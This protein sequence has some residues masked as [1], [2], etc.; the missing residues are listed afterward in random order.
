[1]KKIIL[2]SNIIGV[3]VV[4][5]I[6]AII[7]VK[8]GKNTGENKVNDNHKETTSEAEL[9]KEWYDVYKTFLENNSFDEL[10]NLPVVQSTGTS[11]GGE[12]KGFFLYDMD[13]DSVPELLIQKIYGNFTGTLV[14]KYDKKTESVE[15]SDIY[16]ENQSEGML[17]IEFVSNYK[18]NGGNGLLVYNHYPALGYRKDNGNLISF[19]WNGGDNEYGVLIK[20]YDKDINVVTT[21]SEK[22]VASE[23]DK[24]CLEQGDK[25]IYKGI[26]DNYIPIKFI[27][28][29]KENIDKFVVNEYKSVGMY[30]YEIEACDLSYSFESNKE[31]EEILARKDIMKEEYK[32][33]EESI[34][35]I[36]F[37]KLSK[38]EFKSEM[39]KYEK[40]LSKDLMDSE[41]SGRGKKKFTSLKIFPIFKKSKT[42]YYV[43]T[44]Q[45]RNIV[46]GT[47]DKMIKSMSDKKKQK[48]TISHLNVLTKKQ[49]IQYVKESQ[50]YA[51]I[52]IL[53]IDND[54][55][56]MKV[57]DS[58]N[59]CYYICKF[60]ID[61]KIVDI[62]VDEAYKEQ[63]KVV[64]KFLLNA[65]EEYKDYKY[66]IRDIDNDGRLEVVFAKTIEEL[67]LY[68]YDKEM[69]LL[70]KEELTY[71]EDVVGMTVEGV[72]IDATH[73]V[74]GYHSY[75]IKNDKFVYEDD[76]YTAIDDTFYG[77]EF[78][79]L[80]SNTAEYFAQT[81]AIKEELEK[82]RLEKNKN[83]VSAYKNFLL[84][85]DYDEIINQVVN[86][87]MAV[88]MSGGTV[89]GFFLYDINSD[90]QPELMV[91]K[92]ADQFFT[93]TLVYTYNKS[94]KCVER[95]G[96]SL[97]LEN[98]KGDVLISKSDIR[99]YKKRKGNGLLIY[100]GVE[101]LGYRKDNGW[102]V[103]FTWDGGSMG[104]GT[105]VTATSNVTDTS[106]ETIS[107]SEYFEK[108]YD[109]V[110]FFE[111]D[112]KSVY[113]EIMDNYVP[114]MFRTI[115]ESNINKYI[116]KDY[117][118]SGMYTYTM[119][120]CKA[121]YEN[122][123]ATN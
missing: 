119:E 109:G 6:I 44:D 91:Q 24:N 34:E 59:S 123:N 120:E 47:Y 52:S 111:Q 42:G 96:D 28:I 112:E 82:E 116:V 49:V 103:N 62:S 114:F 61:G 72:Y 9:E 93:G 53:S 48:Y 40:Y 64:Y 17:D 71:N 85:Y 95:Y 10:V 110:I 14:Y 38:Q 108:Y 104:L 89:K 4:A 70:D 87:G 23:K 46:C 56:E 73:Y 22:Y 121:F 32:L 30:T 31:L 90:G 88:D 50:G 122:D 13:N 33:Y 78:H 84:E 106:A 51:N 35:W 27:E 11:T 117:K 92:I 16:L 29:T 20:E 99:N 65:A 45:D 74:E 80:D 98:T 37:D 66:N 113:K 101:A 25:E 58:V 15:K 102:I 81:H 57:Y 43:K 67:A 55:R 69:K 75:Q 97:Y 54:K 21:Y 36:L 107:Y 115:N 19:H 7:L 5:A 77:R 1:M 60:D 118:N 83:W 18:H 86:Q 8:P 41:L 76:R 12:I 94:K 100:D 26:M 39:S 63:Y 68:R 2:I 105:R 3:V 79:V